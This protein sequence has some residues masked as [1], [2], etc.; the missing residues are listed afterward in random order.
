[1][2]QQ[3]ILEVAQRL[4]T[5]RRPFA[6]A[7][8][9][10]AFQPASATPGARA[11]IRGDGQIDGW[12]GGHCAQPTVVRQALDALASG[13]PRL[14]VLSPDA[15]AHS[16]APLQ[17][18]P[19]AGVVEVPMRCAGQG[20]LQIFVEPFLPRA[21]LVIVGASPVART[22]AR[23]G[24]LLEFEVCACDPDADME[25]FPEA[26]RLLQSLEALRLQ[27]TAR[28]SVV[29]ATIGVYDEE[30][31]SAALDSPASYVGLVASQKRF[32]AVQTSLREHGV[33]ED[34]V[35]LLKRPK[36]TNGPALVPGEIAFSVM[37]ELLEVRRQRRVVQSAE[38]APALAAM[39]G[40]RTE[41]IDPI[42][43]MTVDEA[44][45][46]YTAVRDGQT[47]YFCCAGCKA[48]FEASP[49][50]LAPSPSRQGGGMAGDT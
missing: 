47:W 48:E 9:V 34:R 1:V 39:N 19:R 16:D 5:E 25:A 40:R 37:A 10:A 30:A 7:T 6:L 38:T 14:L 36:G 18:Q 21:E 26:D 45:A 11:I 8:V 44:T 12:V 23:L 22:L 15:Q 43:G 2:S 31:V 17:S 33:A 28:S 35:S 27:L 41:A 24:S 32:A 4:R 20:E 49:L 50:P 13:T 42:C 46:R 3:D 29:V